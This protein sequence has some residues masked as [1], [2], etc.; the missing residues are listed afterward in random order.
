[1]N[2]LFILLI[3]IIII[4]CIYFKETFLQKDSGY[5]LIGFRGWRGCNV[6][7]YN[8]LRKKI[9]PSTVNDLKY[10]R[11][12]L[13]C[14]KCPKGMGSHYNDKYDS[15]KTVNPNSLSCR[16]LMIHKK[17]GEIDTLDKRCSY[18]CYKN[19][20]RRDWLKINSSPFLKKPDRDTVKYLK[21][22]LRKRDYIG[23]I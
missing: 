18:R 13:A 12:K 14:K 1:M 23:K 3:L 4:S 17:S 6:K 2:K 5:R 7:E 8:H 20:C 9:N 15:G 22:D 21:C 16:K 19:R 10:N 11:I